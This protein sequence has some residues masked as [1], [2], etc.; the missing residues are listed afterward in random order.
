MKTFKQFNEEV[1]DIIK[2]GI[3]TFLSKNKNVSIGDFIN[4]ETRDKT[5][6]QIKSRGKKVLSK[7]LS[8]LGDEIGK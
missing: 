6:E 5:I 3:S 1:K 2:S 4:S 8:R 7:T